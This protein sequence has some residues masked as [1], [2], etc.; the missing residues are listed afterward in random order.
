MGRTPRGVFFTAVVR[1]RSAVVGNRREFKWLVQ[2]QYGQLVM[3]PKRTVSAAFVFL[4]L[5]LDVKQTSCMF[6]TQSTIR[7]AIKKFCL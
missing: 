6:F 7:F 5:A 1:L 4:K 3:I 2:A